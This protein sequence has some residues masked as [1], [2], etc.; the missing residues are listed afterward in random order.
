MRR[1]WEKDPNE[2]PTFAEL[3]SIIMDRLLMSISDYTELSMV[4]TATSSDERGMFVTSLAMPI[5]RLSTIFQSVLMQ[6]RKLLTV[7]QLMH[8]CHLILHN[9]LLV[10]QPL[11]RTL[12]M[13]HYKTLC[14]DEDRLDLST[15]FINDLYSHALTCKFHYRSLQSS[16]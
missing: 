9:L 14:T 15:S 8:V 11:L 1:C 5:A 10:L 3:T 6:C 16:S 2:R 4:L 7:N 13:S 12:A